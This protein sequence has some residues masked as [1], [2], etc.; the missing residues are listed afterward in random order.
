MMGQWLLTDGCTRR[1]R[2]AGGGGGSGVSHLVA[3]RLTPL[4]RLAVLASNVVWQRCHAGP[5][6]YRERVGLHP[7][8]SSHVLCDGL[9][10]APR[11]TRFPRVVCVSTLEAMESGASL[12]SSPRQSRACSVVM[13]TTGRSPGCFWYD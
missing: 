6:T 9:L 11:N 4:G 1:Q 8:V 5:C 10:A 7:G 2:A 12:Q 3:L 13:G